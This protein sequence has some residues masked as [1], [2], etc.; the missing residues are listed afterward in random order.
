M[1]PFVNV[2]ILL[3]VGAA[4][5]A[6]SAFIG[7]NK[8]TDPFDARKF[9]SGLLTGIITGI[10]AALVSVATVQTAVDNTTLL[11]AYV[12]V[13]FGIIGVDNL[14][15]GLTGA[16]SKPEETNQPAPQP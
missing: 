11:L 13:F 10:T 3:A 2:V 9:I 6:F 1:D 7:W 15:T 16:I 5:G 14:R 12:A 8:G 4:A